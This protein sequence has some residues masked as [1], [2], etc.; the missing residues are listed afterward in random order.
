[1][2]LAM[3][4]LGRMGGNMVRRLMTGGHTCVVWDPVPAAVA[5]LWQRYLGGDDTRFMQVWTLLNLEL[6][7]RGFLDGDALRT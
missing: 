2:Q 6:W 3:I 1:M 4:G 7:C 5:T